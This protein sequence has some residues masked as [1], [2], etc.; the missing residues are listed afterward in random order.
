[1]L[2]CP[3]GKKYHN[4]NKSRC[5]VIAKINT[6]IPQNCTLIEKPDLRELA[7]KNPRQVAEAFL[8]YVV[9]LLISCCTSNLFITQNNGTLEQ[10]MSRWGVTPFE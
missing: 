9:G 2:Y 3:I 5:T 8:K 10:P 7:K 4:T 6:N 1:M